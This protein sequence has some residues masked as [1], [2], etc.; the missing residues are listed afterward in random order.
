VNSPFR[1]KITLSRFFEIL[2]TGLPGL[3]GAMAFSKATIFEAE[4]NSV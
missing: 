4:G 3:I 2:G 1:E